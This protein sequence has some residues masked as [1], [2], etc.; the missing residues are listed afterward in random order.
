MSIDARRYKPI[1]EA[2]CHEQRDPAYC[3]PQVV[4]A[5]MAVA[6]HETCFSQCK[7]FQQLNNFGAIHC[8]AL[9]SKEGRCPAHCAPGWDSAPARGGG[10]RA[11]L[12]CFEVKP[13]SEEGIRRLVKLLTVERPGVAAALATGDARAIAAAMR[14][15]DYFDG[16]GRTEQDRIENYAKALARNARANAAQLREELQVELPPRPP[17]APPPAA[18]AWGL[19]AAGIAAIR[20]VDLRKKARERK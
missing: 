14:K 8:W 20:L 4:Q 3:T 11:Y 17:P 18:G 7:P 10:S 16:V 1:F 12:A 15:A 19:A 9:P 6:R 5:L 2:I 13:S